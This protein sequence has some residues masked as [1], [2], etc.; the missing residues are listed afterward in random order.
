MMK[1]IK[2]KESKTNFKVLVLISVFVFQSVS[3]SAQNEIPDSLVME[4][5]QC[6]RNILNQGK[7]NAN[8]WW[9]GWLTGYSAATAGQGVLYFLSDDTGT[10]Q[11]MALGASTTLLGAIGQLL[12]PLDPGSKADAFSD[13]SESTPE[14][15][16]AKLSRAEE[17]LEAIAIREKDGRSWKAHALSGAVNLSSGLIT[18]IGF[19]RSVWAGIGNFAINSVITEAQIWTQPTRTMK[20]YQSYC[21]KYKSGISPVVY[22]TKPVYYVSAH[23][24]GIAIRVL[25]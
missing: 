20:D 2:K 18:W 6:I 13:I 1:H 5:I 7:A 24:G 16:L 15:R 25:F 17:L 12:M 3:L 23:P 4:R 14:D 22:K 9:Y 21:K 10:K 11:D 19:K 8:L